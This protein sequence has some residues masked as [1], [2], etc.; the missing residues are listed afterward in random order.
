MAPMKDI[1]AA[2]Q[3][4]KG[5]EQEAVELLIKQRATSAADIANRKADN[6]IVYSYVHN[7]KIGAMIVLACQ[8]DFVAR[9]AM[10]LALAKDIC[11]HIVSSP[12]PPKYITEKD[13]LPL[14][15]GASRA[16]FEEE[17]KG[18]PDN[19]KEK[20]I[21]GKLDKWY[22]EVCLLRQKFVRDETTTIKQL[23][24]NV[25]GTMGEKIEIK[26]FVRFSA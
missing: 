14:D 8:T 3:T 2:L 21:A 13:I 18:K 16:I 6:N 17:V 19:I 1:A 22:N 25:S 10:F 24:D 20:I 7:N 5:N 12:M 26:K 15:S 11:M 23:I 4:T 9:N